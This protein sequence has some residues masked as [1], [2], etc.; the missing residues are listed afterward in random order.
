MSS[1]LKIGLLFGGKSP[2]HEI[3]IRSAR[4]V[5]QVI[6]RSHYDIFL[7]YI[8]RSGEWFLIDDIEYLE[9]KRPITEILLSQLKKLDIAFPILHGPFGEDGTVQGLLRIADIPFVGSDVLSTAL[10]MDKDMMKRL[11]E[12]AKI[13]CVPYLVYYKNDC[14]DQEEIAKKIG[15][16]CFIKPAN[17]GSS[18][19]I[20]RVDREEELPGA[21]LDA[22]QYDVKILVEKYIEGD[23]IECAV[24]GND[25]V[26][27]SL[28]ARLTPTHTFYD[29][30]AKYLDPNGAIFEV[31]VPYSPQLIKE[32]Q[33]LA[34]RA[35]R[36]LECRGMARV[37]MFVSLDQQIYINE[38]NTLP[39]FTS[40]SLYPQMWE[41]SGLSY[42]RLIEELLCL[43]ID[44][45]KQRAGLGLSLLKTEQF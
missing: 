41:V 36:T 27:A 34:M 14:L 32:I 1:K 17:M 30:E 37:D 9:Q 38:L 16:P 25:N 10:C 13:A 42:E 20:T 12:H 4:S 35:Y 23:E 39:G 43:A 33:Q 18:I 6:N 28:P 8:D 40:I 19:G 45:H 26:I 7:F 3:S 29:Y 5:T 44:A 15:F 24:L 11:L 21:V 22:F 2:E 31:P